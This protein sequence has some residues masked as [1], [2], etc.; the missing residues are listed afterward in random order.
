MRVP[1][2]VGQ[3]GAYYVCHM[4]VHALLSAHAVHKPIP[5]TTANNDGC[6]HLAGCLPSNHCT[7]DGHYSAGETARG[8]KDTPIHEEL[9]HIFRTGE[10]GH[11]IVI[12][13]ARCF[14]TDP[15]YPG[16][17]E[18]IELVRRSRPGASVEV[19][20]DAIRILPGDGAARGS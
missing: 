2:A 16:L 3:H 20:D 17:P 4:H 9:A 5:K 19:V 11:A 1:P 12:D 14:G 15:A 18:L 10:P 13:D 6:C 7:L 8:E